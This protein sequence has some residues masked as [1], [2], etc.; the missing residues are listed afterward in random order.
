M[1]RRPSGHAVWPLSRCFPSKEKCCLLRVAL[2]TFRGV[3]SLGLVSFG[4]ISVSEAVCLVHENR[5]NRLRAG[6]L[7][8][9]NP[10]IWMASG[11]IRILGRASS[12][13]RG[14]LGLWGPSLLGAHLPR[15]SSLWGSISHPRPGGVQVLSPGVTQ[16]SSGPDGRFP[17]LGSAHRARCSDTCAKV[18]EKHL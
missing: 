15:G 1:A 5:E 14:A 3:R 17:E 9:K 13:A 2:A 11:C 4:F 12:L 18:L 6:G 10:L 7:S 8:C 16:G